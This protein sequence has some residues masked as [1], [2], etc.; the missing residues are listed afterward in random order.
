MPHAQAIEEAAAGRIPFW[1][2]AIAY[3]GAL[4]D[5]VLTNGRAHPDS[6]DVVERLVGRGRAT[7]GPT[8]CRR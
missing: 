3:Q 1:G 7:P 5:R 6:Y 8:C 4:K 2:G